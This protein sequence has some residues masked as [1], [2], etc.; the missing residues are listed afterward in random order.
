MGQ[1]KERGLNSEGDK[2]R[3]RRRAI[4]TACDGEKLS[5]AVAFNNLGV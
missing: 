4:E 3:P 1:R 5:S 2:G